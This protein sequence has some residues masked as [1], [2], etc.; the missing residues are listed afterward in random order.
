MTGTVLSLPRCDTLG[1]GGPD[2]SSFAFPLSLARFG[3]ELDLEFDP[4]GD[5]QPVPQPKP[6]TLTSLGSR[7]GD[8]LPDPTDLRRDDSGCTASISG[9]PNAM[10]EAAPLPEA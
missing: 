3:L 4:D 8:G 2:D 1:L 9:L 7:T 6:R 10:G 5:S